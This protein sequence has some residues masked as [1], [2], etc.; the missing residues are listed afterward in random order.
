MQRILFKN[1]RIVNVFTG[2]TDKADMAVCDDK[3]IGIGEF[4]DEEF[5]KV[6]DL[7]GKYICPGLIDGHI[8]IES[9]MLTPTELAKISLA[10]GTTT[11]IADPHEIANVCG[12]AGIEYMLAASEGL[13][14]TVYI[15]LPSCVPATP[16]DESGAVLDAEKLRPFYENKRVLGL[17]EM[18]NFPGVIYDD[19]DVYDKINDALSRNLSVDGH[20]PGITGNA[21][22]KY[23]AA[24]I[25]SDHECS[26]YEEAM[27]KLSRG[28]W[29]MIRE[30][31]AAKNLSALL[32][33]FDGE[34]R[35]R[36]LLAT[37]DRHPADL[38]S[39]GH[40]D[41]IIRKAV[42]AGKNV[43]SAIQTATINAAACFGIKRLGAIAPGYKADFIIL[44][45]IDNFEIDSVYA[46]GKQVYEK[47]KPV[48]VTA[49]EISPELISKVRGSMNLSAL[50]ASDFDL[51]ITDT[52]KARVIEIVAGE[53]I[54]REYITEIRPENG[55]IDIGRDL[56]KLA[57]IE[58]HN[59]TG[60]KGIGYIKGVG[61]KKGAIASTV[62]HD[63]H[64]LIV[65]GTNDIDM[66]AA[67]NRVIEL[68]GGNAAVSDGKVIA[69]M[70]LD[71]AGLICSVDAKTAAEQN[72]KVRAAAHNLGA[73]TLVEPFMNMAFVSLP[74]IPDLKMSTTGLVDV[75]KFKKVDLW[76]E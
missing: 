71:I 50:K 15:M 8:H 64:N 41:N 49:P 46:A 53:L 7:N 52:K 14:L 40:I 16:F 54:T 32:P 48:Q 67:A 70:P 76:V 18:M 63:S 66:A 45:D 44:S 57:V 9:T 27:Q 22:N 73:P 33:L 25:Q 51:G 11:L 17:A 6:T 58:R 60:H 75:N 4:S 21:L 65:I 42:K 62:S 31:T 30:G 35:H 43:I 10:H 34:C 24:G 59:G 38:L 61:L 69:E 2:T 29:I 39:D 5:D 55:G 23:I 19:K 12:T 56:L 37:D 36:C 13:P 26:S 74:V 28:Q 20:A 68:G 3:I 47:G 72:E 1:A